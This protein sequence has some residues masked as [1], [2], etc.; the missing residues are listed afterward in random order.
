[1]RG[2]IV[3]SWRVVGGSTRNIAVFTD[4]ERARACIGT[5]RRPSS[6]SDTQY[7]IEDIDIYLGPKSENAFAGLCE[8]K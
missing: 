6:L 8:D 5:L 2:F 7:D 1:M 3:Y 4:L